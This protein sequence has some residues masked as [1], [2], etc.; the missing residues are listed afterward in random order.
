MVFGGA[1]VTLLGGLGGAVALQGVAGASEHVV[2]QNTATTIGVSV[3]RSTTSPYSF[4][5]GMGNYRSSSVTGTLCLDSYTPTSSTPTNQS[6]WSLD[7]TT[8]E[9]TITVTSGHARYTGFSTP[10]GFILEAK[11]K[12]GSTT[13]VEAEA[14]NLPHL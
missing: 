5:A 7:S 9:K 2:S 11:W 1:A 3:I 4:K 13:I 10:P 8:C 12:E 14:L 6:K